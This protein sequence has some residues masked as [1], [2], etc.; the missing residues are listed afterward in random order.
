M[1]FLRKIFYKPKKINVNDLINAVVDGDVTKVN[2][3]IMKN[4][5]IVEAK[6][7]LGRTALMH[8]ILIRNAMKYYFMHHKNF[9]FNEKTRIINNH[10]TIFYNL[11]NVNKRLEYINSKSCEGKTPLIYAS[12]LGIYEYVDYLLLHG[13]DANLEGKDFKTALMQSED[14]LIIARLTAVTWNKAPPI[15]EMIYMPI[16]RLHNNDNNEN[17]P[18]YKESL[19]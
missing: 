12:M 16:D 6:D 10:D 14:P 7:I 1:D 2:Y 18:P 19:E 13:A 9:D 5:A 3:L 8:A 15:N 17:L 11:I 4:K